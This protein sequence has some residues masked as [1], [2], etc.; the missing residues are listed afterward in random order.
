MIPADVNKTINL[1]HK[2]SK[3]FSSFSGVWSEVEALQ[4]LH[5]AR[6]S[7]TLFT[8]VWLRYLTETV[9]IY[10]EILDEAQQIGAPCHGGPW[11]L[12]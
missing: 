4:S 7:S 1:N 11:R 8:E 2:K 9:E 3:P 10:Q 12:I 6:E 5:L